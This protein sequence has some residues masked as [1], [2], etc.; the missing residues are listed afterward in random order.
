[1]R[2]ARA[3]FV[4]I[5]VASLFANVI[6]YMRWSGKRPIF[7]VNGQ[8]VSKRDF[9]NYL[10]DRV[11]PQSKIELVQE[12]MIEQEATKQGVLPSEQ[13]AKDAVDELRQ[14]SWQFANQLMAHPWAIL[15][16]ERKAKLQLAEKRLLTK[17]IQVTPEET[18]EEYNQ[19]PWSFDTPNKAQVE[20]AAIMDPSHTNDVKELMDK[21]I[22]PEVI[23]R[24]LTRKVVVF[25]GD[26]YKLT[27]EQPF[28]TKTNAPLF[29]MK[30]N[31]VRVLKP[32]PPL[33][34]SGV[35]QIVVRMLQTTPGH[36]ADFNDPKTKENLR[37]AVALK[38]AAPWSEYLS[39]LWA[40]T[41]FQSDDPNDKRYIE[42]AW[43]P[44]R[45]Q[46]GK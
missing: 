44:E 21:Q 12:M 17:D 5:L 20:L 24:Q 15:D 39:K 23:M 34:Q 30:P 10:E 6:M 28:G 25:L 31:E 32:D 3:L 37:L 26:G 40:S 13:E 42:Q 36:K 16:A 14:T 41:D 45:A 19:H 7:S 4:L 33:L 27:L 29:A 8:G 2:L 18:Q 38:R 35:K 11:G 1:M 22:S 43:W 9:D 46:A